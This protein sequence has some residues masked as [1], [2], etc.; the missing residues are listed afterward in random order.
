M[1]RDD[2]QPEPAIRNQKPATSPPQPQARTQ[3]DPMHPD[4]LRTFLDRYRAQR[5]L[6]RG[7]S[8]IPIPTHKDRGQ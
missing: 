2:D 7:A 1:T 6:T 3:R 8:D 4:D 5:G